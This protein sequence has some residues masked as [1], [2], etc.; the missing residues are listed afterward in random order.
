M[1][2]QLTYLPIEKL[3][4]HPDNPRKELGDLSEL[5]DSIRQSGVYQNLTVVPDGENYKIIIGHRR[6]AAAELAGLTELPCIIADMTEAEQLATML[7]ENMQR[8]DLTIVEQAQGMQ[9][10]LDIGFSVDE[11]S[12]KTGFSKSTVNKRLKV[13]ELPKD[14]AKAAEERG[15]RLE[16]FI[17]LGKIEN[18]EKRAGLLA[19]VG[20]S[21][22]DWRINA[23]LRQQIAERNRPSV[24]QYFK[25]LGVKPLKPSEKWSSKYFQKRCCYYDKEDFDIN[26]AL[27]DFTFEAGKQYFYYLSDRDFDI[28]VEREK[29]KPR[30]KSKKEIAVEQRNKEF[31]DKFAQMYQLRRDF[32]NEFRAYTLYKAQIFKWLTF[33]AM[34][35]V[36]SYTSSDSDFLKEKS[37]IK[38]IILY[39]EQRDALEKFKENPEAPFIAC[40]SLIYDGEGMCCVHKGYFEEMPTYCENKSLK[41]IYAFLCDIGYQL[42]TEE[43]QLLD[44]THELYKRS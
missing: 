25:A 39:D 13:A 19:L 34:D 7:L 16:D 6:R 41:R 31:T 43:Q 2:K 11:I 12:E 40:I 22:F 24:E 9:L 28:K 32:I 26:E 20:T 35:K 30:K 4:P 37:N 8:S 14:A 1:N 44:G 29:E 17:Q 33:Y 5:A 21:E 23:A 3:I 42:S 15:G 36:I 27:K 38:D 10:M 18:A